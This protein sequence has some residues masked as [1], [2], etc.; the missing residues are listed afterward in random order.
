MKE[1]FQKKEESH[2]KER[3]KTIGPDGVTYISTNVNVEY[4]N[5]DEL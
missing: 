4:P 5:N 2:E 1:V 3:K